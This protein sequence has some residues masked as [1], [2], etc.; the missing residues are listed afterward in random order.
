ML[1]ATSASRISA[2]QPQQASVISKLA[3]VVAIEDQTIFAQDAQGPVTVKMGS[4]LQVWNWKKKVSKDFSPI[5]PGDQILVRGHNDASGNL[6]AS[7]VWVNI[8]SFYGMISSTTGNAYQVLVYGP[9]PTGETRTV[10]V[11]AI[12]VGSDGAPLSP[13]DMQKGRFVQT[14]GYAASDG[15]I[16]AMRSIIYENGRPLKMPA[17]APVISPDGKV[18]NPN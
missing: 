3:T 12:T 18:V 15:K 9:K 13:G 6:V 8:I 4:S 10:T 1:I 2:Q 5:H 11:D 17:N 14:V 16:Q 7:S